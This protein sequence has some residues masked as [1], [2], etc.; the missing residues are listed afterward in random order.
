MGKHDGKGGRH[1]SSGVARQ[2]TIDAEIRKGF[3][4]GN[5]DPS[6]RGLGNEKGR[7]SR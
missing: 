1:T 5:Q 2:H 7:D 6:K 3:P 4:V